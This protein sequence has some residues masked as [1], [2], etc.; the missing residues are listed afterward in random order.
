MTDEIN[1]TEGQAPRPTDR[2]AKAREVKAQRQKE[3]KEQ[4]VPVS[5]VLDLQRRI[6]EMEASMK[7]TAPM[8]IPP[9]P[10]PSE[11]HRPGSYV[12]VYE[13]KAGN[14]M[15][16]KVHWNK[17]WIERTYD[18]VTFTPG[19]S[20]AVLPHGVR[21]DLV[22]GV[23]TTVP[24]IVKKLYDDSIRQRENMTKAYRSWRPEE[25]ADVHARAVDN[26]GTRQWSRVARLGVG[27]V[28][29]DGDETPPA[30]S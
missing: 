8:T 20:M 17:S 27:I 11:E 3:A 29:G 18:Q 26:P 10:Q 13:D 14:A 6:A 25:T 23:E 28:V 5:V 2:M 30:A 21:Y 19:E 16:Q 1:P 15:Y 9:A 7:S 22:G 24:R 4:M 12:K